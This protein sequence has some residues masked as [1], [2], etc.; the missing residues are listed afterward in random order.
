MNLV[1]EDTTRSTRSRQLMGSPRRKSFVGCL[2]GIETVLKLW[3]SPLRLPHRLYCESDFRQ[4]FRTASKDVG[5][6]LKVEQN[7]TTEHYLGHKPNYCNKDTPTTLAKRSSLFILH[8][9]DEMWMGDWL[10]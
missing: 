6:W 2:E 3:Q 5:L 9:K 10:N 4:N 7:L 8:I 1:L